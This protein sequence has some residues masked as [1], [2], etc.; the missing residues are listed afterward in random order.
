MAGRLAYGSPFC[1]KH[2][3]VT[4]FNLVYYGC[5]FYGRGKAVLDFTARAE[6]TTTAILILLFD[7]ELT[8]EQCFWWES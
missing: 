7:R 2:G 8:R 4:C 1:A 5:Q 6:L 3:P